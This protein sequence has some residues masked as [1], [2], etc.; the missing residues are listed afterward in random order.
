MRSGYTS[1]GGAQDPAPEKK[2]VLVVNAAGKTVSNRIAVRINRE[3]GDVVFQADAAGEYFVYYMPFTEKAADW[4]YSMEY[5]APQS[6]ADSAWLKRNGLSSAQLGDG[7]WRALPEAKVREFQTWNAFHRCDPMEVIAT[8]AETRQLVAE[9]SGRPYL[10]FPEDRKYPI[11]M[12]DDLPLRWIRRGPSDEFHGEACRGEF[13]VFQVGVFAAREAVNDLTADVGDLR[14]E[15]GPAI[16]AAAFHAFNFGGTD[17]LGRPMKLRLH[18]PRGKVAAL[19]FGVQI[20]V[21][22]EPGPYRGNACPACQ[23]KRHKPGT[24]QPRRLAA[25]APGRRGKRSVA[26]GEAQVARLDHRPGRRDRGPLHTPVY[27]WHKG[28][29]P[30]PCCDLCRNGSAAEYHQRPA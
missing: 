8:E 16:P 3:F 10:L 22:A 5:S 18:V 19:W 14:P 21:T 2:N 23:R 15:R 7:R 11:R 13:Y 25:N 28:G 27:Q 6:T 29:M 26:I 20:P 9:H 1:L 12:S 24:T 17:W 30:R 4:N